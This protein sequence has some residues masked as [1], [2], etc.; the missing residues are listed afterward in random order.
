MH[1]MASLSLVLGACVVACACGDNESPA[2]AAELWQQV[3]D[4]QYRRWQRA[5]GYEQRRA[6]NAPHGDAVDIY[7][8]DVVADVLA[9]SAALDVWPEGS[10]IVKDGFDGSD[11]ELVAVMEKRSDG[12][13]WAEY[14]SDGNPAYSGTPEI[15]I[16]CHASGDDGV[17]AFLLPR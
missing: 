13:F 7:V 10:V 15:C 12:W 3:H 6:T 14:D 16:D 11:L 17:R 1:R 9:S 8:N 2:S 4:D 5:P